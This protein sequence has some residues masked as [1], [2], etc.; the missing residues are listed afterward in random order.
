VMGITILSDHGLES[1]RH[2][3]RKD[4]VVRRIAKGE[5]CWLRELGIELSP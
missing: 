1:Q 3:S 4:C 2:N 5:K